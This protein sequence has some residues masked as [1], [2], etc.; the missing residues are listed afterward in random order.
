[1]NPELNVFDRTRVRRVFFTYMAVNGLL[2][3]AALFIVGA[4]VVDGQERFVK[5][6]YWYVF[7]AMFAASM[8]FNASNKKEL[9]RIAAEPAHDLKVSRYERAYPKRLLFSVFTMAVYA[10]CYI[11]TE[12][13]IFLVVMIV[14]FLVAFASFPSKLLIAKDLQDNGLAIH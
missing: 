1:M 4:G 11:L 6:N 10:A 14:H 8:L 5:M 7:L 2:L 13:N 9:T 3:I 12:K